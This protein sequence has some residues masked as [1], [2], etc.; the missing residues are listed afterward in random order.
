MSVDQKRIR[1]SQR[2][3][4]SGKSISGKFLDKKQKTEL[5]FCMSHTHL[6]LEV[7]IFSHHCRAVFNSCVPLSREMSYRASP[8]T[9]PA[10]IKIFE[11]GILICVLCF[12]FT[13]ENTLILVKIFIQCRHCSAANQ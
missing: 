12:H 5:L 6:F 1:G 13:S 2:Q 4:A 9:S 7:K 11:S 3:T 10:Q 8:L